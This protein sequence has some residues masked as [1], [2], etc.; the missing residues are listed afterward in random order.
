MCETGTYDGLGALVLLRALA[1]NRAEGSPGELLS[2]DRSAESGSYVDRTRY[3]EWRLVL[4]LTAETLEPAVNGR[5]VG[6]LFHDTEHTEAIQRFEFGVALRRPDSPLVLVDSS[7]AAT[8]TLERMTAEHGGVYRQVPIRAA[9]HWYT[10]PPFAF[11][12]FG[13]GNR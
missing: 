11:A 5:P 10:P 13:A 9:D 4:G 6:A 7:G 3:P 12:V 2:F 8:P 1:R